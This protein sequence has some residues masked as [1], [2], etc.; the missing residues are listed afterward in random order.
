MQVAS[1]RIEALVEPGDVGIILEILE[2]DPRDPIRDIHVWLP[3]SEG[4]ESPFTSHF[5]ERLKPFGT[6]RFMNWQMI[7]N[8]PVERWTQRTGRDQARYYCDSGVPLELMIDLSNRMDADPWFCMPH[9]ADDEFV[10]KFAQMVKERLSPGLNVYVEYSNEVWNFTFGQARHALSRGKAL[11]LGDDDFGAA[12]HYYS[13]RSVEIFKIWEGVFGDNRRLVRV[14]GSQFANPWVSQ[15][16][17]DWR[18]AYRHADALAVAPYF[19]N[20]LGR[21]QTQEQVARLGVDRLL[22]AVGKEIDGPSREL[23]QKQAEVASQHNVRLI[24]YEGGQHLVGVEGAENNQALVDLFTAANRSP[25]M[26]DLYRKHLRHWFDAGG[27]LYVVF[28][29]VDKPRKFGSWGVMEYLDQ[30]VSEA[31]KYR[32][33]LDFFAKKDGGKPRD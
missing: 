21:A 22:S 20:A 19:G 27:G 11:G 9:Q 1:G 30:P 29:Y 33:V 28:S 26:Y 18:E 31:P 12:L 3:G 32:A 6:I 8:S 10:R 16:V 5:T 17:L 25:R 13:Q 24:A 14:L 23:I 15:Q 7:N 2:S 4:A